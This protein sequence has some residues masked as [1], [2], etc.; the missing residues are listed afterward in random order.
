MHFVFSHEEIGE[1]D[2]APQA[3]L[4]PHFHSLKRHEKVL[5]RHE[6]CDGFA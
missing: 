2:G 6:E 1:V 5:G 3:L 4:L